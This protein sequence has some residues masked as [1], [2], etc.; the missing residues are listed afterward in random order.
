MLR[1]SSS[2]LTA[3]IVIGATNL[4]GG[5]PETSVLAVGLLDSERWIDAVSITASEREK[6]KT[7]IKIKKEKEKMKKKKKKMAKE[8]KMKKRKEK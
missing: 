5:G 4:A 2:S 6:K 8:K 3:S 7:K 1:I